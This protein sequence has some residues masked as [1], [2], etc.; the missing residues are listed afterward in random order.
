M[1]YT[2]LIPAME[3]NPQKSFRWSSIEAKSHTPCPWTR[4]EKPHLLRAAI[5]INPRTTYLAA[6]S[7][8]QPM[9]PHS[10]LFVSTRSLDFRVPT[11]RR[12]ARPAK[13]HTFCV[14]VC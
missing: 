6:S 13:K 5:S 10:H 2:G 3:V 4:G 9:P 14:G 8:R 1:T 11:A 7:R 12:L